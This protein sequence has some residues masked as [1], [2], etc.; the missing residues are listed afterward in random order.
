MND[1]TKSVLS[2]KE[3]KVIRYLRN[4]IYPIAQKGNED[5]I[6]DLSNEELIELLGKMDKYMEEERDYRI[7]LGSYDEAW[8]IK[9]LSIK[10]MLK[11]T[12]EERQAVWE[13]VLSPVRKNGMSGI[14]LQEYDASLFADLDNDRSKN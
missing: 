14:V 6:K 9:L 13:N 8:V 10:D 2:E 1:K 4:P 7:S 3:Q 11:E 5:F 12:I